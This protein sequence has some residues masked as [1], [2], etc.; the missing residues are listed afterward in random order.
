MDHARSIKVIGLVLIALS[1]YQRPV[2]STPAEERLS[3]IDKSLHD[4]TIHFI[5]QMRKVFYTP[6]Q[7]AEATENY[8]LLAISAQMA[9]SQ[10]VLYAVQARA[11]FIARDLIT[12]CFVDRTKPL[13]RILVASRDLINLLLQCLIA[14]SI[15]NGLQAVEWY[16][17][18]IYLYLR[19][20]ESDPSVRQLVLQYSLIFANLQSRKVETGREFD[21]AF[22][23]YKYHSPILLFEQ[24]E[25]DTLQ[26]IDD[27][28]RDAI[29]SS[30]ESEGVPDVDVGM[31]HGDLLRKYV[32]P[33][34]LE[35]IRRSMANTADQIMHFVPDQIQMVSIDDV[36]R[37]E[38]EL[39][40]GSQSAPNFLREID[41]DLAVLGQGFDQAITEL[42]YKQQRKADQGE[43]NL[44]L[45]ALSAEMAE[46]QVSLYL[47]EYN[48]FEIIKMM[49]KRHRN[50]IGYILLINRKLIDIM[51]KHLIE[52]AVETGLNAVQW[53]RKKI[54][55]IASRHLSR[56]VKML[57]R[58]FYRRINSHAEKGERA[59]AEIVELTDAYRKELDAAQASEILDSVQNYVREASRWWLNC[60]EDIQ[61]RRNSLDKPYLIE[62]IKEAKRSAHKHVYRP[63]SD[64]ISSISMDQ[65]LEFENEISAAQSEGVPTAELRNRPGVQPDTH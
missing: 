42:F 62:A 63:R 13:N 53:R 39:L 36:V 5:E 11:L 58:E 40:H 48:M 59:R 1:T 21:E 55:L 64:T 57:C 18:K 33:T 10:A 49:V 38:H 12:T 7:V 35:D 9:E 44:P 45:V 29:V 61:K 52:F 20:Y 19:H 37:Y 60:A 4:S 22:E 51:V 3:E 32:S 26:A 47:D 56:D 27:L 41:A 2:V 16:R 54:Y 17:K 43:G 8:P 24:H 15:E 14:H 25:N 65:V 34:I 23:R 30:N 50:D 6:R 31:D 28:I 46:V